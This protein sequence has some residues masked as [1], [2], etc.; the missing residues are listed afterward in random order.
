MLLNMFALN[1]FFYKNFSFIK[2][3]L[4]FCS[5]LCTV[6]RSRAGHL[7]SSANELDDEALPHEDNDD[8]PEE[9]AHNSHWLPK[10]HARRRPDQQRPHLDQAR[11]VG[12][13][14]R[15]VGYYDAASLYPSSGE[16]CFYSPARP[17]L[18]VGPRPTGRGLASRSDATLFNIKK[19][20][21]F[22]QMFQS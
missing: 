6:L 16:F 11:S 5:G 15:Y 10:R 7:P 13:P 14:S 3:R 18:G 17:G 9:S 8:D 4:L 20:D 2:R 1:I 21:V 19:I 22:N 12:G